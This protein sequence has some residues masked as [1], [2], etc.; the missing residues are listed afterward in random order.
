MLGCRVNASVPSCTCGLPRP[1]AFSAGGQ[2]L[3]F[4]LN[5]FSAKISNFAIIFGTS[6]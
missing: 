6:Y 2:T 3:A 4:T 5:V 1:L